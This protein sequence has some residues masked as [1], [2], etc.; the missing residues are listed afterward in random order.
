MGVKYFK[1][2][3]GSI[4]TQRYTDDAML[5]LS[6]IKPTQ[7]EYDAAHDAWAAF[8]A[9]TKTVIPAPEGPFIAP[10]AYDTSALPSGTRAVVRDPLGDNHLTVNP[11]GPLVFATPGAYRLVID[12]P[13]PDVGFSIDLVVE[14]P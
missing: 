13:Y 12:P 9:A 4:A 5:A 6:V 3:D 8:E 1:H 2:E 11:A 14:S 10:Y 7:A